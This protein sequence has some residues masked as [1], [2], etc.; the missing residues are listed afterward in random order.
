MNK[1][2]LYYQHNNELNETSYLL[3]YIYSSKKLKDIPIP[4]T[5]EQNNKISYY[6]K[7]QKNII[8]NSPWIIHIFNRSKW[9]YGRKIYIVSKGNILLFI[10]SL[11]KKSYFQLILNLYYLYK[12]IFF[13]IN[14]VYKYMNFYYKIKF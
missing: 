1:P 11:P 3:N 8:N 9:F 2:Y 10:Q 14:K 6:E 12:N 13:I 5:P 4:E 7:Y